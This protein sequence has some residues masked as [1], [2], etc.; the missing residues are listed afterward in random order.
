[1]SSPRK[2]ARL[3][4]R[5]RSHLQLAFVAAVFV[6]SVMP[7][8]LT[9]VQGLTEETRAERALRLKELPW[10]AAGMK[11]YAAKIEPVQELRPLLPF[12][13]AWEGRWLDV[14]KNYA[15]FE[16]WFGDRVALRDLMIRSKNELD[17]RLFR[18][19]TRV[20]FGADGE[21]YGRNLIDNELTA[22]Q[23]ILDTPAKVDA[24]HRGLVRYVAQ[25][26]AQGVTPIIIAPVQ[27]EYL[28]PGRLPF[29]APHLPTPSNFMALYGRMKSDPA[30]H[31]VDSLGILEAHRG[32][33]PL[34][35]RQDFHWTDLSAL[36]VAR[37][38]TEL[39]AKLEGAA[40]RWDHR[41]AFEDKPFVGSDARFAARLDA[42]AA[43]LEPELTRTWT[44]RHV[45]SGA[46]PGF[47]F[48][49]GTLDDSTLLP[50][51]CMYGNSF[52]DGLLVAGMPEYFQKFTKLERG[53]PLAEVPAL[54]KGRCK[55]L[56]V[57]VLDI[58]PG[59]WLA[60]SQ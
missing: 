33:F 35:Y 36:A 43:V 47:E 10:V 52:S 57:L 6:L 39:I 45:R 38:T 22:T 19:S 5:A 1:M 44:D 37:E 48:E 17:Y 56:I 3:S 25:L 30:L 31:F 16:K 28:L 54:I 53:L 21:V 4:R 13:A 18:S 24:I 20:Y 2:K 23:S 14:D 49:T 26:E 11:W 34:Y 59:H 15:R 8:A 27:K 60:F 58:Q 55:Y 32:Q 7:F 42:Q 51:T 46:Q 40:L 9:F 50:P 29:F 12:P 41:I